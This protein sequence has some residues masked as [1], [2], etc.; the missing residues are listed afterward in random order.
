MSRVT[1]RGFSRWTVAAVEIVPTWVLE[2]Q[3]SACSCAIVHRGVAVGF[4][5]SP[6]GRLMVRSLTRSA[7]EVK[8]T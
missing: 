4:P 6:G 3:E 5:S 2:G 7:G 1:G 8:P